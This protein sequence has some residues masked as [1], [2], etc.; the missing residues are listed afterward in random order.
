MIFILTYIQHIEDH[1][2]F[3]SGGWLSGK[4]KKGVNEPES[5]S[6]VAWAEKGGWE[7]TNF[8]AQN[9]DRTWRIL[10]EAERIAKELNTTVAAVSLRWLIQ[11]P[12][13]TSVIIGAKTTDQLNQNLLAS[14]IHLSDEQMNRLD[15]AS[16]MALPGYPWSMINPFNANRLRG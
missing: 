7:A 1:I 3:D 13:V 9:N 5:N 2:H 14:H 11:R 8:S 10:D 15:K 12:G 6:R 4:Y 16:Q